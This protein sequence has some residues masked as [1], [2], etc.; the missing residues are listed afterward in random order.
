MIKDELEKQGQLL[1]FVCSLET[2][3]GFLLE[4][5]IGTQGS[6]E[7]HLEVVNTAM[8]R[9]FNIAYIFQLIVNRISLFIRYK[10]TNYLLAYQIFKWVSYLKLRLIKTNLCLL[11]NGNKMTVYPGRSLYGD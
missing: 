7:V 11:L 1:L 6:H 5:T 2:N 9:M 8:A 10:N 3:G 4:E